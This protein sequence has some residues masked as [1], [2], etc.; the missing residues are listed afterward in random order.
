MQKL[1]LHTPDALNDDILALDNLL[2]VEGEA[3]H[4]VA[5]PHRLCPQALRLLG[6]VDNQRIVLLHQVH[7]YVPD[8]VGGSPCGLLG[9]HLGRA[10]EHAVLCWEREK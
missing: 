4:V 5:P 6:V 8:E 10:R 3:P 2:V 9:E 1:L 7:L